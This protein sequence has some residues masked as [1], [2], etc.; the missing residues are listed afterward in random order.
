[1]KNSR[2]A[3]AVHILALTSHNPREQLTSDFIANSVNTN[4]VVI[5]RISGKL[6]KAGLLTSH[7][8]IPGV[9]VTKESSDISLLDIY[10]AVQEDNEA[11]FTMHENPNPDCAVGRNIQAVLDN[12]FDRAQKAMENELAA[13]TLQDVLHDLFD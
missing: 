7:A 4:P 1:M 6:K 3:V 12:K 11:T 13:Q 5:R 8:G 10:K 2:F 9:A